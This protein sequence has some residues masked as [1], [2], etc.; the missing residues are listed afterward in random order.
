MTR[1]RIAR[2]V[3]RVEPAHEIEVLADGQ[4]FVEAEALGHVADLAPDRVALADD[5]EPEAGAR[6][7]IRAEQPAEHADG[8]GLAAAVGPEK[9]P[10]LPRR[11]LHRQALDHGALAEALGEPVDVDG[12]RRAH[13]SRTSTGWPG[14]STV[15]AGSR[16]SAMTTS[17]A[18]ASRLKITGGVNSTSSATKPRVADEVGRA[19][20]AG[21]G[22]RLAGGEFGEPSLRDEEADLQGVRRQEAQHGPAGGCP[23]A[24][25]AHQLL[26]PGRYPAHHDPLV[27]LP[28]RLTELRFESGH[29]RPLRLDL[30]G[31]CREPG[32]V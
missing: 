15:P 6:A 4:V 20:V 2:L 12:E 31:A 28:L 1:T 21:D 7:A 17:F 18:L 29:G 14:R 19:A 13:G 30:V 9:A 22:D 25:K 27:E 32:H 24:R 3:Q 23:L 16:A 10:D 26:D 8:R 11:H 5:V